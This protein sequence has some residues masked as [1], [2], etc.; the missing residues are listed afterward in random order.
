MARAI[1]INKRGF[2]SRTIAPRVKYSIRNPL[3]APFGPVHS[4][5][6]I[7]M[8]F[9]LGCFSFKPKENAGRAYECE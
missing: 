7:R 8:I 5:F 6:D 9:R 3:P 2:A 1:I 4:V